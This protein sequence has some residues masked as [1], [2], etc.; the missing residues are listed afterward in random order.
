M[1]QRPLQGFAGFGVV[2]V[3]DGFFG[4]VERDKRGSA[5]G[6][7]DRLLLGVLHYDHLS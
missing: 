4:A 1:P 6:G 2:A 3:V 5:V 7:F